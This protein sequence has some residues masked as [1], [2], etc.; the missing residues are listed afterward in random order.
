M[1]GL[2]CGEATVL[3][4]AGEA[5]LTGS[6]A[7]TRREGTEEEKLVLDDA[8]TER[9]ADFVVV[10]RSEALVVLDIADG[11][12]VGGIEDE[13]LHRGGGDAVVVEVVVEVAMEAVA[14]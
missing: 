12:L 5:V 8:A 1:V 3:A 4:A 6:V 10:I 11:L 9:A 14:T 13:A 7:E 2:V